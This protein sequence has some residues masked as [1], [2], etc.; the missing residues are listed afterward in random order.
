M[1]TAFATAML[2]EAERPRTAADRRRE[3]LAATLRA[4]AREHHAHVALPVIR[5]LRML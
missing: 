5:A 1:F 4:E 2:Y 3:R